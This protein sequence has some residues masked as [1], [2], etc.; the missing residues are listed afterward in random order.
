M[1]AVARSSPRLVRPALQR[2]KARLVPCVLCET[3][4]AKRI[5]T[6]RGWCGCKAKPLARMQ[7][8]A[9]PMPPLA[10]AR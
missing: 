8:A 3:P 5:T 2:A 4:T 6:D 7:G 9:L 10:E 1:T